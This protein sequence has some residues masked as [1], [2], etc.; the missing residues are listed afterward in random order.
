MNRPM[1]CR[2]EVRKYLK[3]TMKKNSSFAPEPPG[4]TAAVN[5]PPQFGICIIDEPPSPT[6]APADP[7]SSGATARQTAQGD[8][9]LPAKPCSVV[10]KLAKLLSSNGYNLQMEHPN[11]W[12][13]GFIQHKVLTSR[14]A[15]QPL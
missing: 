12:E 8:V 1:N 11:S 4:E 13:D 10:A 5:A 3:T 7:A 14:Q 9:P 2:N 6:P 15:K